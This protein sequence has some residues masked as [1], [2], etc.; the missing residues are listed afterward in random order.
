MDGGVG[1]TLGYSNGVK[2][3]KEV[4]DKVGVKAM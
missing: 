2:A 4:V 3:L 1:L